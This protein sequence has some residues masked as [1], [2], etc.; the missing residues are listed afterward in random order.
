MENVYL[1]YHFINEDADD[2]IVKLLGVYTSYE[3]AHQA[4]IRASNH[5]AFIGFPD[6]FRIFDHWINHDDWND[7]F[8]I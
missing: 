1:L 6:G 7:G 8:V 3:L 5:S 4:K 2:E